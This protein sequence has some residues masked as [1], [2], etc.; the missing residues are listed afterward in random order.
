MEIIFKSKSETQQLGMG[1]D[2]QCPIKREVQALLFKD[3]EMVDRV[4]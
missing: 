3:G 1:L 2:R 4:P